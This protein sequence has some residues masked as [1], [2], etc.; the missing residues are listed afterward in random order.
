MGNKKC[1]YPL[2]PSLER[3]R[4]QFEALGLHDSDIDCF[5]KTFMKISVHSDLAT[6][7]DVLSFFK[8]NRS[9]FMKKAFSALTQRKEQVT[10]LDVIASERG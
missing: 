3:H 9:I 5:H 2:V 10:K 4:E 8:L 7:D 6:V 1:I